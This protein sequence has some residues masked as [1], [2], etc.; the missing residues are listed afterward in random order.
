MGRYTWMGKKYII[1]N[2]KDEKGYINY[3]SLVR[4]TTLLM[5]QLNLRNKDYLYTSGEAVS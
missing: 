2:L 1:N 3:M 4:K 5:S